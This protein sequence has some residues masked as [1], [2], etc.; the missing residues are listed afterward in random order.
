VVSEPV[1]LFPVFPTRVFPSDR[2]PSSDLLRWHTLCKTPGHD[3][4]RTPARSTLWGHTSRC[5]RRGA[6]RSDVPLSTR[7]VLLL[8]LVLLLGTPGVVAAQSALDL[9]AEE[10]TLLV[11]GL[12]ETLELPPELPEPQAPPPG[13]RPPG[14][15]GCP[16][17]RLGNAFLWTT[18]I[19][20]AYELANLIRGQDT[21]KITPETWWINM[22]RGWEWDLDDFAVNQIGH[23][24]QGNNYFTTGRSNGLDFWE[25]AALTAFGSGTW[26][27]FGETNQASLNDFINT[28]LGGIALGE[29]F[30]RTAWLVRDT[31]ATGRGRLWKEIGAMALDPMSGVM[32]FMSGDA[33]R[34]V[35]KPSDMV[36]SS[37]RTIAIFGT[38]WRGSN[39]EA[40]ESNTYGFFETDL[41]YGDITTGSSNTPY[42]AFALR[43]SFG[44]GSAFSEARV[45]GRLYSTPVGPTLFTFAQ[46]YQYNNNPA[47][48]FGA[49]AFEG[50]FIGER[51]LSSRISML[52]LGGGGVT[53]LGAVDSIPLGGI[54]DQPDPPPDAGQGV[55]TGPRYYDYGPGGNLTATFTLLRDR[56]QFLNAGY[57]LYH[58]HVL[59][60]VRANH[61]LQRARLDFTWPLK[62]ALGVGASTEFFSRRT[63]YADDAGE[64]TYHFPQYRIFLSWQPS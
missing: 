16:P 34:V 36:P 47:Y 15:P 48:Q 40:I 10:D 27:Y 28:T 12:D 60:G 37:L 26:E 9:S 62:G 57:E 50:T 33:S 6:E 42:D 4:G 58:L 2:V 7:L 17:R 43:L 21:A 13:D 46:R 20:V 8:S 56:R 3:V 52:A 53:V 30:H 63:L 51:R 23:P 41:L 5:R 14:C 59:D 1:R 19:N 61:I 44:G 38:L 22:K 11:T 39:T 45:R 18:Y 29:M 31:Q 35:E 49:Q 32:R 24:Y 25:S 55:S 54:I 64:A